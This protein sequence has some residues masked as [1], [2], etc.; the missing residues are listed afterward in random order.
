LKIILLGRTYYLDNG[1][2]PGYRVQP[3]RKVKTRRLIETERFYLF[4]TGVANYL[5]HR[6]PQIGTSEFGKSFEQFILMELKAYQA[7]KNSELDASI[8]VLPWQVF[9]ETLWAG[10]LGV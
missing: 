1:S 10:E 2:S 5:A 3:W 7:Y 4:D 9:L 6:S 8:E